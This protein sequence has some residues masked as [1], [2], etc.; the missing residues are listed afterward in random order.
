MSIIGYAWNFGDG[1]TGVGVNPE[2]EYAFP[3]TYTVTLTVTDDTGATY[4]SS[5]D[6]FI[7]PPLT[8]KMVWDAV[9]QRKFETGIDRGVLYV[10]NLDGVP[11]NGLV[12]V[13]ESPSG[14]DV[15]PFYID[16]VKYL[17]LV[18]REEYEATIEAYIYPDEFAAC[19]GTEAV[20]NGLFVTHQNKKSFGLCYR[21]MIGDDVEGINLGYKIHLV[22]N[23][24]VAP[25]EKN[26]KTIA[27]T[28]DL[29]NF[30]WHI[31]AKPPRFAGYK[32]T[33]HFII[34]SR[35]TPSELLAEIE[36]ILYGSFDAAA[37]L[38]SVSELIYLFDEHQTMVF[39]AG[40]IDEP[41]DVTFDGGATPS[42]A[43]TDTVDGG[44]P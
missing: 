25:S 12:S 15:T 44:S 41:F 13:S 33:A 28:Y 11:W 29:D 18:A 38:P 8:S 42:E 35:S 24:T 10:E 4:I 17:N 31:V 5:H 23:A 2:H 3:G 26:Y 19:E 34:D 40:D 6:V 27:E 21:T 36:D 32:P 22:Y 9:G 16:G 37:R 1:S 39:D 7:A 30:S 43:Q 20:D 14:G